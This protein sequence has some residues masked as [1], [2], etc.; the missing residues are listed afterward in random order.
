MRY[1]AT[2]RNKQWFSEDLFYGLMRLRS[3]EGASL[4]DTRRRFIAVRCYSEEPIEYFP[5]LRQ[6]AVLIPSRARLRDHW[7]WNRRTGDGH[8]R[9]Q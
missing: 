5:D 2:Q 8:G 9:R 1:F 4:P 3:I 7:R 6:L